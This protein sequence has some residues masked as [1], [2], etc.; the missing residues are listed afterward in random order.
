MFDNFFS[1]S[2]INTL[3]QFTITY[4]C[5]Y[6]LCLISDNKSKNDSKK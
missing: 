3:L 6:S 4:V 2:L 5:N 1:Y